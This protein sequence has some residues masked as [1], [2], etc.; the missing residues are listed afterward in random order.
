VFKRKGSDLIMEKTLS[1]AES[2]CGFCFTITHLD[3]RVLKVR[4]PFSLS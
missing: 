2:L 1:L 3:Q 4:S